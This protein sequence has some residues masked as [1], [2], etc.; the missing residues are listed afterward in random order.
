M[1]SSRESYVSIDDTR[2]SW[3]H[4]YGKPLELVF[5]KKFQLPVFETCLQSMLVDEVHAS[6]LLIIDLDFTIRCRGSR[7]GNVCIGFEEVT[8]YSNAM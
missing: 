5:G 3:P 8:R 2:K 4:G 1:P 7:V 6:S